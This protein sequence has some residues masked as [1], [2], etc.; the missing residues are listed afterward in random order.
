MQTHTG[1]ME[2]QFTPSYQAC[3]LPLF[4][5]H[6]H[7]SFSLTKSIHGVKKKNSRKG[8]ERRYFKVVCTSHSM[9]FLTLHSLWERYRVWDVLH[10]VEPGQRERHRSTL[11]TLFLFFLSCPEI[12]PLPPPPKIFDRQTKDDS[13]SH[14]SSWKYATLDTTPI[15]S[16][17]NIL[18]EDQ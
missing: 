6:G 8:E 18:F 7:G 16:R 5:L 10:P 9:R 15:V 13:V 4:P 1:N 12:S 2:T 14:E 3:F 17:I 11:E